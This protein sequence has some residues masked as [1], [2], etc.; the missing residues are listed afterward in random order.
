MRWLGP[1]ALLPSAVVLVAVNVLPLVGVLFWGWSLLL[2]LV[3]YWV[4]SG[5]IGVLNIFKIATARG[6]TGVDEALVEGLGPPAT[7]DAR[8][9]LVRVAGIAA[10]V[11]RVALVPFFI[12]HYGMFWAVHGIFVFLLPVF[13]S[14][15]GS[16]AQPGA[17]GAL[18]L[19]AL[20]T[21][22]AG[23]AASHVISFFTNWIGRREYLG[24]TPQAQMLSVYGRVVVLH[25]TILGGA[26]LVGLLGTPV[27]ALVLL[28]VLKTGLDLFFHVRE[29]ARGRSQRAD[30]APS[31]R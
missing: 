19:G 31:A 1:G 23:L 9:A 10:G 28:V 12:F 6:G 27:A 17:F 21:A 11:T 15:A 13:A 3:L 25:V 18:D 4:E 14:A 7:A 30:Y 26:A 2:I 24:V 16:A 22:T 20:V 5:I 8:R 29:H